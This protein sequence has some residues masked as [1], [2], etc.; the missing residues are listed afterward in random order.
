MAIL[1][2]KQITQICALAD[3]PYHIAVS[4]Q[5][6]YLLARLLLQLDPSAAPVPSPAVA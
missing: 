6:A 5:I 2:G 4:A 1:Q 3:S